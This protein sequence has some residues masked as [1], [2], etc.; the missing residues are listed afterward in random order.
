M[1]WVTQATCQDAFQE[2]TPTG[3]SKERLWLD[4]FVTIVGIEPQTSSVL[5]QYPTIELPVLFHRVK[6]TMLYHTAT[7]KHIILIYKK[8]EDEKAISKILLK[9]PTLCQSN[10]I[11]SCE[12]SSSTDEHWL[13]MQKIWG[14]NQTTLTK[15]ASSTV[16]RWLSTL[17]ALGSIP[18]IVI[19]HV[20]QRELRP[21]IT[22]GLPRPTQDQFEWVPG[23]HLG[24]LPELPRPPR[25]CS[26]WV[27]EREHDIWVG[28][29][30]IHKTPHDLLK[31]GTWQR[32]GPHI[33]DFQGSSPSVAPN[34]ESKD[35]LIVA[36]WK[37]SGVLRRKWKGYTPISPKA[38]GVHI[39][40]QNFP[41]S[42]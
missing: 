9:K 24:R 3:H 12:S 25:D 5:S 31:R 1:V 22:V 41:T 14:S 13:G 32:F 36:Q 17:D 40:G 38:N 29:L 8:L 35:I 18:P 27:A 7:K 39:S 33:V 37:S 15:H 21:G 2:P 26:K 16:E 6:S 34:R 23:K 42:V 20:T 28:N 19:I 4:F 11:C 30:G 10:K